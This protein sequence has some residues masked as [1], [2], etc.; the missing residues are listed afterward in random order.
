MGLQ[1]LDEHSAVAGAE[2]EEVL[3]CCV[4]GCS[5]R[6]QP[7]LL[8]AD[9]PKTPAGRTA[10]HAPVIFFCGEGDKVTRRLG[11]LLR[12]LLPAPD[13]SMV[14][15]PARATGATRGRIALQEAR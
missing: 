13:Q 9:R 8:S 15:P 2:S 10:P 14:P 11:T 1:Y 12:Q 7:G 5:T 6:R 4:L 3:L